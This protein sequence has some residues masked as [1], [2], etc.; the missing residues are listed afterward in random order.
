MEQT[1]C[2]Y[3]IITKSISNWWNAKTSDADGYGNGYGSSIS[4]SKR[5]YTASV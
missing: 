2:T 1:T 3:T 4:I 5:N